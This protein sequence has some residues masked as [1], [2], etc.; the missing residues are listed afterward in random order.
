M[1]D[2]HPAC[3]RCGYDLHGARVVRC[4]ECGSRYDAD[5]IR[6]LAA[7]DEWLRLT[8]VRNILVWAIIA[9]GF[10]LPF[11]RNRMGVRGAAMSVLLIV[12]YVVVFWVC[13]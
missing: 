12:S 10:A 2:A 7:W 11:V 5:E 3:P 1:P 9:A 8:V 6:P 13:V 4:P